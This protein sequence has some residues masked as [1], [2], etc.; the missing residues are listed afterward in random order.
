MKLVRY[1]SRGNEKPGMLDEEGKIRDLSPV[2][3]DIAGDVLLPENLSRLQKIDSSGLTIVNEVTRFGSCIGRV[4][5]FICVGLNYVDHIAESGAPTPS[6]P[7]LFMKATSAICGP[8]DD[9]MI[10]RRSFKT[11]WEVELG[12]V[13]GKPATYVSEEDAPR[14]VAGFCIANDLSERSFQLEGSGQ[15]TKGKSSDTFGPLGPWLVTSDEIADP[16]DLRLWL[17]V[18]DHVFQSGSTSSMIFTVNYLISYVSQFMSLQSGDVISTGTPP[19]VGFGQKPPRYLRPGDRIRLGIHGLGEQEQL[20][21]S[22]GEVQ[23]KQ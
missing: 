20:V 13:I 5:K 11:D 14:H 12:V 16:Q 21:V 8:N 10:P 22:D 3:P 19:G 17:K 1:G 23:E 15:W 2:V 4:G 6:E 9:V 18:N 7:V